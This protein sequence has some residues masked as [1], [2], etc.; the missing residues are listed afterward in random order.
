MSES[1]H[2]GDAKD[3]HAKIFMRQ[4]ERFLTELL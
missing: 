1:K 3:T 2:A 4:R